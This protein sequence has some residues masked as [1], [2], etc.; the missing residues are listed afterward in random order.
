MFLTFCVFYNLLAKYDYYRLISLYVWTKF[1]ESRKRGITL[2]D[3][4]LR[5][6]ALKVAE[7]SNFTSFKASTH[8]LYNFKTK[9]CITSRK[10]TTFRMLRLKVLHKNFLRYPFYL[11]LESILCFDKVQLRGRFLKNKVTVALTEYTTFNLRI[12]SFDEA[13]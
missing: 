1:S 9:Y 7:D 13:I 12:F 6:W 3:I 11:I 5:K 8:W 10:I 4:D 2:H